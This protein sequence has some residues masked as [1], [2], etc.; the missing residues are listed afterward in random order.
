MS[1]LM[2]ALKKAEQAKRQGEPAALTHPPSAPSA[3]RMEMESLGTTDQD[4]SKPPF[5]TDSKHHAIELEPRG[6]DDTFSARREPG[7]ASTIEA[8]PSMDKRASRAPTAGPGALP[9]LSP[10]S[11]ATESRKE[12]DNL[13]AAKERPRQPAVRKNFAII[14]G[15]LTIAAGTAIGGYVWWQI[16]PRTGLAALPGAAASAGP[17]AI[18][19][20][21]AT[22]PVIASAP[23]TPAAL[24]PASPAT[25]P[26]GKATQVATT[27]PLGAAKPGAGQTNAPEDDVPPSTAKRRPALPPAESPQSGDTI[28]ITRVPQKVSPSLTR[29]YDAYNRGETSV[30]RTE[31]EAVLKADPHNIDALHGMAAIAQR[32]GKPEASVYYFQRILVANPKDAIAAAGLINLQGHADPAAAETRL[33]LIA[34]E[35]PDNPAP[36]FALG[37]LY[38]AKERW[39]D[40]QQA[41]FK[42]YHL[43]AANPDTLFN[44]AVSLEH[45]RQDKLAAQYYTQSIEAATR[46]PYGFDLGLAQS[47]LRALQP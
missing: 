19:A 33:K 18:V 41:Y 20:Q 36:H 24:P 13:F 26:P 37:N 3:A 5:E 45:L 1:L 35:Q 4:A 30:A 23:T 10:S 47:R 38:A 40:A 9:G 12:V 46:R 29:A 27:T 8:S 15:L 7:L 22:M 32:D 17:R 11:V 16:Q 34:A 39:G 6:A 2:D 21:P 42:A 44:L 28:R 25:E 43:D 14:A 31:Y